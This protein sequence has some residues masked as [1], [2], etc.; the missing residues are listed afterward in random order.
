[1]NAS[2]NRRHLKLSAA[3]SGEKDLYRLHKLRVAKWQKLCDG[4]MYTI[5]T[6]VGSKIDDQA[7]QQIVPR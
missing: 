7:N 5:S 6:K 2:A 4:Q 3:Q 1:M